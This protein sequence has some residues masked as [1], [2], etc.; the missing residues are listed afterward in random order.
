[1][2]GLRNQAQGLVEKFRKKAEQRAALAL[3]RKGERKK[4][5]VSTL[6][7]NAPAVESRQRRQKQMIAARFFRP[8]GTWF[9]FGLESQR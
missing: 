7:T 3:A 5:S 2:G 8:F 4:P 9:P 6:G 1:M